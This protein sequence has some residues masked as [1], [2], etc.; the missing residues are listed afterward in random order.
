M[1]AV[2]DVPAGAG[3]AG[4]YL[5]TYG[6]VPGDPDAQFFDAQGAALGRVEDR[7]GLDG[8]GRPGLDYRAGREPMVAALQRAARKIA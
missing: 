4:W 3:Q 5:L 6:P 7:D 2:R 8:A 1:G